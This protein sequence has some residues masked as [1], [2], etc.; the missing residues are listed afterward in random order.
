MNYDPQKKY[1]FA[2]KGLQIDTNT[3]KEY[4]EVYDPAD[5]SRLYRIYNLFK[6][7]IPDLPPTLLVRVNKQDAFGR[8]FFCQD[9][10]DVLQRQ[11][12]QGQVYEF[13]I[14]DQM[15]DYNTNAPFFLVED[16]FAQHRFYYDQESNEKGIG[17]DIL[18]R[19]KKF[20][21]RG[22]LSLELPDAANVV[23]HQPIIANPVPPVAPP[24][25]NRKYSN[26]VFNGEDEGTKLEYKESIAFPPEGTGEADIDQQLFT[27]VKE[28]A[29]F[30]NSEGGSIY[31]GIRDTTKEIVGIKADLPHLNDGD[32]RYNGSYKQNNDGFELKIRNTVDRYCNGLANNLIEFKFHEQDGRTFCE[33]QIKQSPRPI[34]V[35]GNILMTRT[36]NRMKTLKGEAITTFIYGKSS[37]AISQILDTEDLS[38]ISSEAIVKALKDSYKEI[39]QA[40][41]QQMAAPQATAESKPPKFYIIWYTD[42]T[43]RWQREKSSANNIYY[44]GAVY[45]DNGY[46]VFC[47]AAGTVNKVSIKQFKRDGRN[48][49]LGINNLG[50]RGFDP[51]NKPI[52]IFIALSTDLI[53]V[54]STD[55]HGSEFIKVHPLTDFNDTASSRNQGPRILPKDC[56]ALEYRLIYSSNRK[57]IK[58][59]IVAKNQTATN[60]GF[61]IDSPQLQKEISFITGEE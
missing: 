50:T 3:G 2:V 48:R 31:I 45:D 21:D 37:V 53:S 39:V 58:N 10:A 36:G 5:E 22:Y 19:V 24:T 6:G 59:L 54:Y 44:Q 29:A 46:V 25:A 49:M 52:K 18:L 7:Q 34:W 57:D 15:K 14:C 16:D 47:Y 17:D 27:I 32:D 12:E 38:S 30:L 26:P 35:N 9:E 4:A 51:Q 13:H 41:R 20:N 60:P 28:I 23:V 61:V 43:W 42:G 55:T 33:I 11:Y 40:R 56:R 8:T 1:T